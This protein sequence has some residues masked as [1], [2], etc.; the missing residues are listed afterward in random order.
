MSGGHFDYKQWVCGEIADQ[1]DMIIS[2]N[3]QPDDFGYARN[4][5]AETIA[6]FR[7]AS[8]TLRMAGAMAHEVDWLLSGD[9]GE[10]SFR[11]RW[12]KSC[13]TTPKT[14]E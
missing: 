10:E 4:F 3:A 6:R 14:E 13:V 9:T 5:S 11:D 1:I 7:E 12:R 2:T 8:A